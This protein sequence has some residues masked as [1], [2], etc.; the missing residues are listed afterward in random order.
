M[1][2]FKFLYILFF[3][4]SINVLGQ[5]KSQNIWYTGNSGM[6][7]DFNSGSPV[8]DCSPTLVSFEGSGMFNDPNTGQMIVYTNGQEVKNSNHQ[9]LANATG[10]LGNSSATETALIIPKSCGNLDEFYVFANNTN[11][12]YWSE[13]DLSQGPNGTLNAATK[14]TLLQDLTG[15]RLGCAPHASGIGSWIILTGQGGVVNAYRVDTAGINP[16]PIISTTTVF[17]TT[18]T[19]RGS[20]TISTDYSKL[21]ISVEQQGVYICDFDISTGI[22]SNFIHIPG[23][24]NGYSACFSSDGSKAYYTNGYGQRLDQ[25]DLNTNQVTNLDN[26]MSGVKLGPD[27]KIY[28]V[29]YGVSSLG[30]I[31]N[32]NVSGTGCNYTRSAVPMGC[33][34]GWN[35]PNQSINT[36]VLV[37]QTTNDT[38]VCGGQTINLTANSSSNL[39]Y[40]WSHGLGAGNNHSITVTNSETYYVTGTNP[41]GCTTEDSVVVVMG[42]GGLPLTT[43]PVIK[44]EEDTVLLSA[45][46]GFNTYLWDN[47]DTGITTN[48]ADTGY[49][50]FTVTG[51]QA[52]GGFGRDSIKVEN[53]IPPSPVI[54][55]HLFHCPGEN[56]L[57]YTSQS[58]PS[59]IWSTGEVVN[60][61]FAQAGTQWVE[62]L[63]INGCKGTDTAIIQTYPNPQTLSIIG[64]TA[65]CDSN[66]TQIASNNTYS[67]YLWSNGN[68]AQSVNVSLGTYMLTVTDS[69]QCKTADTVQIISYPTPTINILGDTSFCEGLSTELNAVGNYTQITWSNGATDTTIHTGAGQVYAQVTNVH[70]CTNS[71]TVNIYE[72]AAPNPII[73]GDLNHCPGDSTM[74]YT[75]TT[76]PNLL[77]NTG[78]INQSINVN[79]GTYSVE[80]TAPNGCKGYDTVTVAEYF[81]QPVSISGPQGLC[82]GDSAPLTLNNTYIQYSWSNGSSSA[83][84]SATGGQ[85][86]VTV[87]D[88][89]QCKSTDS[90]NITTYQLPLVNIQGDSTYCEGSN[91]K[92]FINNTDQILWSIGSTNQSV[93][94][95]AG[96][97]YVTVKD[98]NNCTNSDSIFVIENPL[99]IPSING[100]DS[101][102]F[103]D[104]T[105]IT[106]NLTYDNYVWSNNITDS[107]QLVGP[108]TYFVQVTDQFGCVGKSNNFTIKELTLPEIHLRGQLEICQG[109]LTEIRA[110]I[111]NNTDNFNWNNNGTSLSI[112][113]NKSETIIFEA[114][115]EC[116]EVS[117]SVTVKVH[118]IPNIDIGNDTALCKEQKLYLSSGNDSTYNSYEWTRDGEF[119]DYEEKILAKRS[120]QYILEVNYES[121]CIV[122]DTLE[123][124]MQN[125]FDTCTF[126]IPN[127]FTPNSDL[128]NDKFNP[129]FF[130]D[131][132]VNNYHFQI[133][134]RWGTIIYDSRNINDG[135]DG[136]HN[137]KRSKTDVYVW[138]LTY[139]TKGKYIN[140]LGHVTLV[141]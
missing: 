122:T 45:P 41:N 141:D 20:I 118:A 121:N 63:D 101:L 117:D 125:C 43:Q 109:E 74:L 134:N 53:H 40:N 70:G 139:E 25:Y 22:A 132:T 89:N 81:V 66:T 50:A 86:H 16:S 13:I 5:D 26:N 103:W 21:I 130:E 128:I 87:T 102:C 1:H 129:V 65:V 77:W 140:K 85:Y 73:N 78:S 19:E 92:L 7:I 136:L 67:S 82:L 56:T 120:G 115:N 107:S 51:N 2:R 133:I 42:G 10:L 124:E 54:T 29:T 91:A 28:C 4:F 116:G 123:V 119:I 38:S 27:N 62:V 12:V 23:S 46:K 47:G 30:V 105:I 11:K 58:Y 35:L 68:T 39:T 48:T 80:A 34:A 55:G 72:L 75:N 6:F 33:T 104:S 3:L 127:A 36:S 131:C 44:C 96:Q 37:V 24:T 83:F 94:V 76:Y 71:D 100:L 15:E 59:L 8:I 106:T 18:G 79:A 135:W 64:N 61:A 97:H 57:L 32:P 31:A 112:T 99:P 84:I 88:A 60:P 98:A 52:C 137:G 9:T 95:N 126:Y 110:E 114:S 93:N 14:N 138:Q 49:F 111:S 113:T 90:V 69:N 17:T 108:G